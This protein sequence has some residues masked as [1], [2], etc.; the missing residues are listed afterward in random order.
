V[1]AYLHQVIAVERGVE[2]DA[3]RGVGEI[4]RVL[5]VGGDSDPL[6]GLSRTHRSLDPEHYP[7]QPAENRK[8][9][10]TTADL[11]ASAAKALTRL[12]DLKLTREAGNALAA[13]DVTVDGTVLL[14]NVP[15]GYLLFLEGKLSEL[16]SGLI[17][18]LPVLDPA[19]EWHDHTADPALRRGVWASAPRETTSR[20][21]VPQV[22]V[23][24]DATPEHPAQVRPYETD[25]I[26]GY[27]TLVKYSGQLPAHVVQEIRERAV[28]VLEAVR[29][30]REQA[31]TLEVANREA[32]AVILGH[33]FG[34]AVSSP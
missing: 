17:D 13:A 21:R 2:A 7:V 10:L 14:E 24:Y 32:G 19:E 23:L 11:L 3:K 26:T 29:A 34:G 25:L 30:A 6:T 1:P 12:Y 20:T 27:W 28:K 4:Q 5:A 18:R 9:Q 8:V 16:V 31:N 15:I 22:Q 33:I